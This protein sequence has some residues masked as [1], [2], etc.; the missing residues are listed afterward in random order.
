M[1]NEGIQIGDLPQEQIVKPQRHTLYDTKVKENFHIFGVATLVLACIYAFCMFR[2]PSGITFPVFVA[3]VIVYMNYCLKKL[4]IGAKKGKR[5]YSISM[6]LLAVS[7]F[8]TDDER[9]IFFNMC[10]VFLLIISMLLWIFCHTEKWNLG[11][12]LCAMGDTCLGVLTEIGAPFADAAWYVKNKLDRKNGKYL[13]ILIG[14]VVAVPLFMVMLLLLTSADVVF[15]NMAENLLSGFKFGNI[16]Q[17]V[18]MIFSMFVVFYGILVFLSKG[19]V[20]EEVKD[21][22]KGEPLIAIPVATVLS[23]MYIVFSFVQIIYLFAGN[24]ELPAGYTYAEYAREGFF[25]LLAV[26]V[27]NLVLVLVGLCYFRPHKGL[28]II[29]TVMSGCTFIMLASSAMRMIIYIQYYYLTFLRILVLWSL[30]VLFF[31]F[32]GVIIYIYKENFPLFRY[33]MVVVTVLYLGLSFSHPDYWIA[34]VNVAGMADNRSAF[35]LG[36]AYYDYGFLGR[37]SADAA[38]IMLE[39]AEENGCDLEYYSLCKEEGPYSKPVRDFQGKHPATSHGYTSAEGCGYMYMEHLAERV[40]R[41]T[42]R[43]FNISRAVADGM[44]D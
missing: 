27:L 39:W 42:I 1:M 14:L 16:V 4:E 38:P 37:L 29:L 15:K 31:I 21:K 44:G 12:F 41:I 43:N 17:I 13:Y 19:S 18:W 24:M 34:K 28:K 2:N 7:T 40:D 32:T 20:K 36:D 5:F 9:I 26:G 35:F 22:R 23:L 25:Q 8:C 3:A 33:S 11:K 10:G 30:L 6:M